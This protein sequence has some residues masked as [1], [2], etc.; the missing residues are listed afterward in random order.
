MDRGLDRTCPL[1]SGWSLGLLGFRG[2]GMGIG[3][4]TGKGTMTGYGTSRVGGGTRGAKDGTPKFIMGGRGIGPLCIMLT[5]GNG[6][7]PVIGMPG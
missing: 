3:M 1:L 4:G 2:M 6:G 5:G 7:S